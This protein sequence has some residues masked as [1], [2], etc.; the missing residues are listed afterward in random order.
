[1]HQDTLK[2]LCDAH[3]KVVYNVCSCGR[4]PKRHERFTRKCP[5]PG[6]ISRMLNLETVIASNIWK[7]AMTFTTSSC[8]KL[9][10]RVCK[11]I[12]NSELTSKPTSWSLNA[13]SRI[14]MNRCILSWQL[15]RLPSVW[16]QK[17][18]KGSFA[19][20]S[21]QPIYPYLFKIHCKLLHFTVVP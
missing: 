6:L 18:S 19:V 13:Q 3:Y 9:L 10:L 21:L 17:L 16:L 12:W 5:N 8:T 11:E 20:H 7:A 2:T 4:R 14:L 1:M 15:T